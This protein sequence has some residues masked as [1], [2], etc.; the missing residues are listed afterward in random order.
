[1]NEQELE[2]KMKALGDQGKHIEAGF[3]AYRHYVIPE[4]VSDGE[5]ELHRNSWFAGAGFCQAMYLAAT[6]SDNLTGAKNI[7]DIANEIEQHKAEQIARY[8]SQP[9]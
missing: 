8:D 3:T 9:H 7:N 5:I 4:G 6:Q 2:E 1:M